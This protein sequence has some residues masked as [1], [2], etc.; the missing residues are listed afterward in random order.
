MRRLWAPIGLGF[1]LGVIAGLYYAWVLNPVEYVDTAPH[2][3]REDFKGDYL[4]LIASAYVGTGDIDRAITRLGLLPEV[5]TSG[6]VS[7]LAE[8]RQA[9]G[10][11]ASEGHALMQ[12]AAVLTGAPLA[13][14]SPG[15]HPSHTPAPAA[16]TTASTPTPTRRSSLTSTPTRFQTPT[17][18]ATPAGPFQLLSREQVCDPELTQP[19]IQVLVRDA[20]GDA[21]PGVQVTVLWDTGEDTFYTGLKPEIGAGYADFGMRADLTYALQIAGGSGVIRDLQV[22]DC[23]AADGES[24]AG[25]WQLIFQRPAAQ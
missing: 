15:V 19:L 17:P 22:T 10:Y 4:A 25:T 7:A 23:A 24:Y 12:L 5:G 11:P 8:Q 2:S 6:R 18:T 14:P 16:I 9:G 20:A 3:L 13:T 21:I 1:I